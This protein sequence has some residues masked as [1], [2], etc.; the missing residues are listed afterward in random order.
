MNNGSHFSFGGAR[1][2]AGRQGKV[3]PLA[4]GSTVALLSVPRWGVKMQHNGSVYQVTALEE[5]PKKAV[6]PQP[7]EK[8][9]KPM[10]PKQDH[11]WQIPSPVLPFS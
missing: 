7:P 10:T 5:V 2:Q 11:P 1:H 8:P 3:L 4:P 6:V 9:R